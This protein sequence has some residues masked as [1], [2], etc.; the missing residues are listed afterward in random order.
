MRNLELLNPIVPSIPGLRGNST[1]RPWGCVLDVNLE[2][3]GSRIF[4]YSGYDNQGVNSGS[5]PVTGVFG[6]VRSFDGIDDSITFGRPAHLNDIMQLTV[7]TWFKRRGY[8][9]EGFGR[10]IDKAKWLLY[11]ANPNQICFQRVFS[12]SYNGNWTAN[13][14]IP[15]NKWCHVVVSYDS[16]NVS[17]VPRFYVNGQSFGAS[18]VASPIGTAVSDIGDSLFVGN[19]AAQNRGFDGQ[20]GILRVYNRILTQHE[21]AQL[22]KENAWRYGLPA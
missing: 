2:D 1:Y 11:C 13:A 4:D 16:S 15:A 18:T 20:M 12:S 14:A 9:G 6:T 22:Y 8:G 21:A 7:E 3:L 17:N 10:H 19:C 5:V